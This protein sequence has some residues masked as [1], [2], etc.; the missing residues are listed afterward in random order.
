[1]NEKF[2]QFNKNFNVYIYIPII[3]HYLIFL[4]KNREIDIT[5]NIIVNSIYIVKKKEKSLDF[6][7]LFIA[8]ANT[9][10]KNSSLL[11]PLYFLTELSN[12]PEYLF[13]ENL[14]GDVLG[15]SNINHYLQHC[16]ACNNFSEAQEF[17]RQLVGNYEKLKEHLNGNSYN[18][19]CR[20]FKYW[21]YR[22]K[23]SDFRISSTLR[24]EWGNCI[25]CV[26]K[27]LEN[28]NDIYKEKCKFDNNY[29]S[30]GFIQVQKALDEICSIKKNLKI[31]SDQN[32]DIEKCSK[33]YEINQYYLK[34]ILSYI[35]SISSTTSWK[36]EYFKIDDHCSLGKIYNYLSEKQCSPKE[37]AQRVKMEQCKDPE[38]VNLLEC[39]IGT[40][41]NLEDL[42][43]QDYAT[44]P[45]DNL[46]QLYE[47]KCEAKLCTPVERVTQSDSTPTT[48]DDL[49][50]LWPKLC[51]KK[52]QY[53]PHASEEPTGNPPKISH[54]QIP[55]TVFSSVVGTIFFFL[56]LYKVKDMSF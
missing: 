3:L 51:T 10:Y 50:E 41:R 38:Q 27:I 46:V 52:P 19:Y 54:L 20:Y 30:Y 53:E 34:I 43:Q 35:G 22:K 21:L 33:I 5:L 14:D 6:S 55:V 36:K 18:K 48:C 11:L 8:N 1:M 9:V 2:P 17:V 37:I 25:F 31:D 29:I 56:F 4:Y 16:S 47:Q 28:E 13:Y 44:Y 7:T 49:E 32:S 26:W 12:I 23:Y 45:C 39:K 24:E 42:F 15:Q 40:C